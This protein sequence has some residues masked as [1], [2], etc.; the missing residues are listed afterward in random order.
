MVFVPCLALG[1]GSLSN[2]I[3]AIARSLTDKIFSVSSLF[4][5]LCYI[6]GWCSTGADA[7]SRPGEI[8]EFSNFGFIPHS[9]VNW[10][11]EGWP[12]IGTPSVQPTP[13]P[14]SCLM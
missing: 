6:S 5:F 3:S 2:L 4:L 7:Q 1:P 8:V 12:H 13:A 9:K 11:D 10:S 14:E